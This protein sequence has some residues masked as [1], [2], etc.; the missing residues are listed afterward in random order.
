MT[1]F[2]SFFSLIVFFIITP[3]ISYAQEA[4][5][6][7]KD[8]SICMH[9]E[10]LASFRGGEKAKLKFLREN[11]VYPEIAKEQKIQGRVIAEVIVE[12]DGSL[13][14]IKMLRSVSPECDA[15]VKRV[16]TLMPNWK[17]A[18]FQGD[19][20]RTKINISV[21]FILPDN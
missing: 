9:P 14:N 3:T 19:A 12:K 16:I 11:I 10:K 21:F 13:S 20:V 8:T 2:K 4:V 17:A 6:E 7:L 15:E 5:S 1:I 18:Y